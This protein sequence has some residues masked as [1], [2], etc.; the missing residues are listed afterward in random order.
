M[1][2]FCSAASSGTLVERELATVPNGASHC[3][4]VAIVFDYACR[5]LLEVQPQGG[6]CDGLRLA[7]EC[8]SALRSLGLDVDIV[9]PDADLRHYALIVLP[10]QPL[11]A[12]RLLASL[13]KSQAQM[14]FYPR[15]GSKVDTVRIPDDLPPSCLRSLIDIQILRVESLRPG[16]AEPV[17][18]NQR[19]GAATRWR[20]M[21]RVGASVAIDARFA[22]GHP[23]IVRQQ[24][25]RYLAGWFDSDLQ[26]E[27]LKQAARDAGLAPV[28]LPQGVRI[29]R[30]GELLFA[31]NYNDTA[32][33]LNVP[34]AN[35]LVG[36]GTVAAHGV[37]I[38][39]HIK[40][41][42]QS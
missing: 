17:R 28:E 8:Y 42:S 2:A 5:W 29:R 4:H 37:S 19:E 39:Q 9:S 21:L 26:R 32:R 40:P 12:P 24:R 13:S 35:W 23:A 11:I 15:A 41:T 36:S 16:A 34:H 14:V 25:T 22:D 1:L 33:T 20:E 38:A 10:A 7:F 6:D 27:V 31:M 18:L 30:R 3:A